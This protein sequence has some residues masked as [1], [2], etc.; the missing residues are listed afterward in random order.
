M[1]DAFVHRWY[2]EY[3]ITLKFCPQGKYNTWEFFDCSTGSDQADL[4]LSS[5]AANTSKKKGRFKKKM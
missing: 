5:V 2:F 1:K 3:H 4:I